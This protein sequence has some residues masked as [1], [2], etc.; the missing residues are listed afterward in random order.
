MEVC[1]LIHDVKGW[2]K[3]HVTFSFKQCVPVV[4]EIVHQQD[5]VWICFQIY[6][7]T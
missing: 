3:L 4:P 5:F 7:K 2:H 6:P 1:E